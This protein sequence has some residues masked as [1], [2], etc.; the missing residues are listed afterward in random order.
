[1]STSDDDT[2]TEDNSWQVPAICFHTGW[3]RT[4]A[5]VMI[6]K[7]GYEKLIIS[8]CKQGKQ[9]KNNAKDNDTYQEFVI[10]KPDP[11]KRFWWQMKALSFHIGINEEKARKMIIEHGYPNAFPFVM[12]QDGSFIELPKVE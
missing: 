8:I 12:F 7:Y 1:M 11:K 9:S 10:A 2:P 4:L 3:S 5:N 6:G